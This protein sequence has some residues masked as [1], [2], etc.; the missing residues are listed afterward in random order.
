M[1][2]RAPTETINRSISNPDSIVIIGGGFAGVTLAQQLEQRLGSDVTI[3]VVSSENH[4]VF[5]PMLPEVVGRTVS[6]FDVVVPGR[7]MT[8]RTVW[9]EGTATSVDRARNLLHYEVADGKSASLK[10]AHLI[11]ACGSGADLDE[12]PGVA[13][14]GYALKTVMD[15][16]RLGNDLIAGLE[17]AAAEPD[18]RIRERLLSVTV[19]G[20]G[21]SGV[22]VAGHIADLIWS[23]RP[24]YPQLSRHKPKIV[25]LH[26]GSHLLPELRHVG[27]SA[28][29]LKNLRKNHIEVRLHSAVRKAD[30]VNVTLDSGEKIESGLIVCTV[31]TKTRPL[32]EALRLPLSKGRLNVEPQLRVEGTENLWALGDCAAIPDGPNGHLCPATAQFALAEARCLAANLAQVVS[33]EPLKPFHYRPKGMFASIGHHKAVGVIYGLQVSGFFAWW[34]WRGVYL[35]KLPTL[36]RKLEVGLRWLIELPFRPNVVQLR[37]KGQNSGSFAENRVSG[38]SG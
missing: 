26:Q 19:I 9:L 6:P 37:F 34:L 5:T 8:K 21:F 36:S 14:R 12:I 15:A 13:A 35:F 20:G 29:T 7:Q 31:G 38:G 3:V 17:R 10:Y 32:I 2:R 18:E 11:F 25:L 28:K 33:Q 22:E 27:L 24:Y 23:I 30:A 1:K 4:L 16:I